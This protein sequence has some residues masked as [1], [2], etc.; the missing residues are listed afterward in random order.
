MPGL[1]V[2]QLHQD[3]RSIL[4]KIGADPDTIATQVDQA[5]SKAPKVSG[6]QIGIG[7]DLLKVINEAEKLATKLGDSYVTSEHL[8]GVRKAGRL[9]P[10]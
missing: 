9:S 7:N 2:W 10:C 3:L 1:P 8:L 5:I 6:A 4:E